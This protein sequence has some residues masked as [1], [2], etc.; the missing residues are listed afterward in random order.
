MAW[1]GMKFHVRVD[2]RLGNIDLN[3]TILGPY[4]QIH[5]AVVHRNIS[6]IDL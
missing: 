5:S 6:Y 1:D 3:E 4:A 2:A